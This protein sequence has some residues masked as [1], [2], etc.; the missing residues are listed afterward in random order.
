MVN[1]NYLPHF[2]S[3]AHFVATA[4]ALSPEHLPLAAHFVDVEHLPLAEHFVPDSASE[5]V[6]HPVNATIAKP[7]KAVKIKFFIVSPNDF[8]DFFIVILS[9]CKVCVV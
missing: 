9:M 3:A 2:P 6:V 8:F 5:P 4:F 7:T 1:T